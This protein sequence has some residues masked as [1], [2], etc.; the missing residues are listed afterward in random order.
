VIRPFRADVDR[1]PTGRRR[2]GLMI[3]EIRLVPVE[4]D[5]AA[6]RRE[7]RDIPVLAGP[8]PTLFCVG[9]AINEMA[10]DLR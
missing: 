9:A 3:L 10:P 4:Q 5:Q 7:L 1:G 8:R 2:D 6:I